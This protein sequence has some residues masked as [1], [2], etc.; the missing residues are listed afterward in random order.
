M[1]SRSPFVTTGLLFAATA[2]AIITPTSG[3][4]AT[5]AVGKAR[6][7]NL[8]QGLTTENLYNL[9]S[10]CSSVVQM[11]TSCG[12]TNLNLNDQNAS[13]NF[14]SC[15]CL[16]S[17]LSAAAQQ[18][19][20]GIDQ[21][22]LVGQ[23]TIQTVNTLNTLCQEIAISNPQNGNPAITN[24]VPTPT[25][26]GNVNPNS[27]ECQSLANSI[28]SCG[29]PNIPAV[30]SVGV[31]G[32]LCQQSVNLSNMA[33]ACLGYL[34]TANPSQSSGLAFFT[35]NYCNIYATPGNNIGFNTNGIFGQPT[36]F[37]NPTGNNIINFGQT[38]VPRSSASSVRITLV[39]LFFGVFGAV[40]M[41]L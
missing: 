6:I 4:A 41:T 31:A 30:T 22:Q 16:N 13:N 29:A 18:C 38:S 23:T 20:S 27:Q 8:P 33:A 11:A 40:A 7:T 34:R 3:P 14:Y 10:Q 32:C 19:I 1:F 37:V 17:G 15:F 24:Y 21:S 12:V 35:S 26:Y 2:S 9:P 28:T 39:S 25:F 36:P 5:P